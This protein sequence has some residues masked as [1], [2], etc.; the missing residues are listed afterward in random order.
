M[1]NKFFVFA[2]LTAIAAVLVVPSGSFAAESGSNSGSVSV[3]ADS[4]LSLAL[5]GQASAA[6][7]SVAEYISRV[8]HNKTWGGTTDYYTVVDYTGG[9]AG[10]SGHHVQIKFNRGTW[11]YSGANT[12]KTTRLGVHTGIPATTPDNKINLYVGTGTYSWS[13]KD[14][15]LCSENGATTPN[16]VIVSGSYQNISTSSGTCPGTWTYKP[17]RAKLT[18]ALNGLGNGTYTISGT[19]LV[20]DAE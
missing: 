6:T 11:W 13:A 7:F 8:T 20:V 10:L 12:A 5:S 19:M 2:L 9:G 1:R 18:G 17:S 3:T 15:N 16:Y 14:S 4:T